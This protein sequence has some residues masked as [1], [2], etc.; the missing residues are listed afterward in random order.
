[1]FEQYKPGQTAPN[2][3]DT[4]GD[5]SPCPYSV[6]N[7]DCA[8]C[9]GGII[10]AKAGYG[11]SAHL[12]SSGLALDAITKPRPVIKCVLGEDQCAGDAGPNA[13]TPE[14]GA[15]ATTVWWENKVKCNRVIL[16][17][18]ESSC[19]G[20]GDCI[21]T[22]KVERVDKVDFVQENCTASTDDLAA[23]CAATFVDRSLDNNTNRCPDNCTYHA[24]VLAVEPVSPVPESCTDRP[25]LIE[26]QDRAKGPWCKEGYKGPLCSNCDAEGWDGTGYS[27]G[28]IVR[29]S[30]CVPCDKNVDMYGY[31][32][33]GAVTFLVGFAIEVWLA[34]GDDEEEDTRPMANRGVALVVG[35]GEYQEWPEI[36][37]SEAE[38]RTM[39]TELASFGYRVVYV[40]NA[41]KQTMKKAVKQF[42][43]AIQ[44]TSEAAQLAAAVKACDH[45]AEDSI[46]SL[47]EEEAFETER[48]NPRDSRGKTKKAKGV[49][50]DIKPI[51]DPENASWTSTQQRA[52]ELALDDYYEEEEQYPEEGLTRKQKKELKL[53]RANKWDKIADQVIGQT[54]EACQH[55]AHELASF[56]HNPPGLED[57]E[58]AVIVFY[59]GHGCQIEG[60][61]YLVPVDSSL[62]P[63]SE[64]CISVDSVL[65]A[66]KGNA[67]HARVTGPSIVMLD[68]SRKVS[69]GTLDKSGRD[70]FVCPISKVVMDDPVYLMGEPDGWR[71]ERTAINRYLDLLNHENRPYRSPMTGLKLIL[72]DSQP[73][74]ATRKVVADANLR[75]RIAKY[76]EKSTLNSMEPSVENTIL[77]FAATPNTFADDQGLLFTTALLQLLG[78]GNPI[79]MIFV[80]V[81]SL[82]LSESRGAQIS[83][84]SDHLTSKDFCISGFKPEVSEDDALEAEEHEEAMSIAQQAHEQEQN[85][86]AAR[87]STGDDDSSNFISAFLGNV[88]KSFS[89]MMPAIRTAIGLTQVLTGMSFACD[90]E[91]PP[92]FLNAMEQLKVLQIDIWSFLPFGCISEFTYYSSFYAQTTTPPLVLT[93]MYIIH[94]LRK[95]GLTP[96][97]DPPDLGIQEEH[98]A[99]LAGSLNICFTFVFLIYPAV[100]QT[101]FVAFI[102]QQIDEHEIML[103]ADFQINYDTTTH[104][105]LLTNAVFM[106]FVYPIGFPM[107]IF[108]WLFT[109]R[110]ELRKEGSATR[111]AFDPLV[112]AYRLECWY[113]EAI[114]MFRKIILTG[115]MIF[116]NPGS[117][118]QL[119]VGVQLSAF[120]LILSIKMRPFVTRFNNNFKIVTDLAV[121]LTFNVAI[122]LSDRV[123]WSMEPDFITEDGLDLSLVIVNMIIP[124]IVVILE[125][126]RSTTVQEDP[127][128][129]GWLG[130]ERH[131]GFKIMAEE[132]PRLAGLRHELEG[133]EL[134]TLHK[135]ARDAGLSAK[136][137]EK[138]H[139]DDHPKSIMIDSLMK[140][141]AA[142]GKTRMKLGPIPIP[143]IGPIKDACTGRKPEGTVRA[144]YGFDVAEEESAKRRAKAQQSKEKE[145]QTEKK[146][147]KAAEKRKLKQAFEKE[148]EN[149]ELYGDAEDEND[150]D[151]GQME[152]T[153][154]PL[155]NEDGVYDA[156]GKDSAHDESV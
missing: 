58:I 14:R 24:P 5:C 50:T 48:P 35:N 141:A 84:E 99:L 156:R 6:S 89:A 57:G 115:L 70:T 25:P 138:V 121:M 60:D 15:A 108:F 87:A 73:P 33:V 20:A 107:L 81:R 61:N 151:D 72:P 27:R 96:Q 127:A 152:E 116:W 2:H 63:F 52:L 1:M 7:D 120:F 51:D 109:N 41:E 137:I 135:H 65:A 100:S 49:K 143:C 55:R 153:D 36:E 68:A 54:A 111:Q 154:N 123:D 126:N 74:Q 101:I 3:R 124:S 47:L 139:T 114:E 145:E 132:E 43:T 56:M 97:I 59:C 79:S 64:G 86:R 133:L 29:E 144:C 78:A 9:N 46:T 88:S 93:V 147:R 23:W 90:I 77:V 21:Y 40:S 113:W 75:N 122:L 134:K 16:D 131:G 30:E 130:D 119:V 85:A 91:Y 128:R 146:R 4:V 11:V 110:E 83:W 102:S 18:R 26:I 31:V 105:A 10:R 103:R 155:A 95:R 62:N 69:A 82:V 140:H 80:K 13:S 148:F 8:T 34:G 106:V 45:K 44:E 67:G 112:G 12:A 92:V 118:Q 42:T 136:D 53:L 104:L 39:A 149:S 28:G 117:V 66:R 22:P 37:K 129:F 94:K 19:M 150:S 98:D 71:Y 142:E 125:L 32:V 76:C 38:A 17:G